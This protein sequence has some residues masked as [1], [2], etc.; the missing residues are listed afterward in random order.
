MSH[1]FGG[2]PTGPSSRVPAGLNGRLSG[3]VLLTGA[4]GGIGHAIA[5]AVA[6]RAA[7]LILTA[8]RT[9][10]LEP[11]AADLGA[12]VIGCDLSRREDVER[13][14]AESGRVDV[15][16]AN[17]A[18]PAS[19]LLVELTQAEIDRMLEVNLRAP[20]ALARALAPGMAERRHGHLAFL[21]SLSGKTASP[22]SSVYSATKFG[23]RGFALGLRE[24]LR[25]Y[26][27][28]VSVILPGFVR[29]AGMFADAQASLPPGVGT[30]SPDEVARA[31]L[32]AIERNR[33][34]VV[35]APVSM[36]LGASIGGLAPGLA[37]V[38]SRRLGSERIAADIAAG[39]RNKR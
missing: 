17:A 36:R 1:A 11:L 14:S 28:G 39:Q 15:L 9:E 24:D 12:R 6:P 23:V 4:S 25:R 35:V 7:D 10:V 20:I 13:L 5:R 34:E 29:E 18:L 3:N 30:R 21:S 33:G 37:S 19:G 22:A 27:V 2:V 31:V 16:I 26:G 38:V 8:R 32:S